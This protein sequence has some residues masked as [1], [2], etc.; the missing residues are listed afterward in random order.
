M[1]SQ[2][3]LKDQLE[4]KVNDLKSEM[5][6]KLSV[7]MQAQGRYHIPTLRT[8]LSPFF[9]PSSPCCLSAFGH[10]AFYVHLEAHVKLILF[11]RPR[12]KRWG[13]LGGLV[14]P[15]FGQASRPQP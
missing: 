4:K 10:P 3:L 11:H 13:R 6:D 8:L 5:D 1:L 14:R 9:C 12:S 7:A 2:K 15:A